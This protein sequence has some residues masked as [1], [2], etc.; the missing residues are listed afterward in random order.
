M[1]LTNKVSEVKTDNDSENSSPWVTIPKDSFITIVP[2]VKYDDITVYQQY[3]FGQNKEFWTIPA[4]LDD[5]GNVADND[6]CH[7]MGFVPEK[8][9]IMP[10]RVYD[11][12]T[13]SWSEP[14]YYRFTKSVL[15]GFSAEKENVENFAQEESEP[16]FDFRY[17]I[18]KVIRDDTTKKGFTQYSVSWT[19]RHGVK[20]K[21]LKNNLVDSDLDMV[22]GILPFTVENTSDDDE[23]RRNIIKRLNEK[24]DFV[25]DGMTIGERLTGLN[26]DANEL[27]FEMT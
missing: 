22:K 21:D 11:E 18:I 12:N 13:K 15:A 17:A 19:G 23:I 10:V 2:M 5:N 9:Y 20:N 4:L 6:P 25:V 27:E 24:S 8:A 3:K 14:K 7:M 26:F 16:D 1:S